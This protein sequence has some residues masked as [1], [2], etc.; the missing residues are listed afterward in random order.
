MP[1]LA[2]LKRALEPSADAA[3]L[4]EEV[5]RLSFG[6]RAPGWA[7]LAL[8]GLAPLVLVLRSSSIGRCT[9][10]ERP[11]C[12][13]CASGAAR[14]LTCQRCARL[15]VRGERSD[16]RVRRFQMELDRRHQRRVARVLALVSLLIPGM[17]RLYEGQAGSGGIRIFLVGAAGT[18][19]LSL[20]EGAASLTRVIPP[21]F[22]VGGLALSLPAFLGGGL[23][24]GLYLLAAVE[25][26]R[27]LSTG[28]GG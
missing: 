23:L 20:S 4:A 15:F 7:W 1:L 24:I 8:L 14:R 28:Y 27:R 19:L 12:S 18:L 5:R 16:P 3:A 25:A 13:R 6:I 17:A 22:E 11:V 10:C 9:R 21:P 26:T 2:Y